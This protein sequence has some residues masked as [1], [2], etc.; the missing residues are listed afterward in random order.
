MSGIA[1]EFGDATYSSPNRSMASYVQGKAKSGRDSGMLKEFQ[2]FW[3]DIVVGPYI[4]FGVKIDSECSNA[5]QLFDVVNKGSGAEQHRHH[6]VDVAMYNILGYIWEI[7]VNIYF[8]I[9]FPSRLKNL[10]NMTS[11][12]CAL[13]Q[14]RLVK[15][16]K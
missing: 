4:S 10:Y 5:K 8:F 2:G 11:V 3:L 13:F 1:F 16:I 12:L 9:R 7:E 14:I 15:N 6:T